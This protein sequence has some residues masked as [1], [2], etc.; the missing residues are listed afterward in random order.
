ML[1]VTGDTEIDKNNVKDKPPQKDI[2][3]DNE[4]IGRMPMIY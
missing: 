1:E 3:Q 2:T 4:K